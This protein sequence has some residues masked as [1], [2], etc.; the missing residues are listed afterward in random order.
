MPNQILQP[1]DD[2]RLLDVGDGERLEQ[3][4][5]YRLRRPDPS[6]MRAKDLSD[7]EWNNI[8]A[9][10]VQNGT[11]G[12]WEKRTD[13]PDRWPIQ[14]GG[15]QLY[16]RLTPFKHTGIFP[17]QA[18]FWKWMT[19]VAAQKER[20]L[21]ILNL[22]AYSGG[23]TVALS[24]AGHRV[25]HVDSAKPVIGWARENLE[26]NNLEPTARWIH[27]DALAF[28]ARELRRGST[29]DAILLDPPA[30][31]HGPDGTPWNVKQH[32][33]PLLRDCSNLLS[34]DPAFLLINAYAKN[35]PSRYIGGLLQTVMSARM[36]QWEKTDHGDLCIRAE[37]GFVLS[38]GIFGRWEHTGK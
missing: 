30:Y 37:T 12:A 9:A 27:D 6:M 21:Q 15:I 32:L 36:G 33:E 29:Y 25:T 13:I 19:D 31:G 1:Q 22:F 11:K 4:G 10:F 17:E 34:D 38:T 8:D 5:A 28:V 14:H 18:V 35:A 16:A 7:E 24:K 23:A 26:L 2:Y 20:P 3:W